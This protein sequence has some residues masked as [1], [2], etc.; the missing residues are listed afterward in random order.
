[1]QTV[2]CVVSGI[3]CAHAISALW[4]VMKDPLDFIDDCYMVETYLKSYGPCIFP[5]NGEHEW[6][7][8]NVASPLP[9]SY[10][11]APGRPKKKRRRSEDEIQ[12]SK[13][14]R[15]K[16]SCV[17]QINKCTFCGTQGHNK[18]SCKLR[19][20]AEEQNQP[21]QQERENE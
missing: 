7:R 8:T 4:V 14:K 11:K 10:G 1:M 12:Q 9:T 3:P 13:D 6:I 19:K 15:K 21:T 17:G 2:I 16:L 5:V 18:R 20:E